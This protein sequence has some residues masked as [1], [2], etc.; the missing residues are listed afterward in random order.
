MNDPRDDIICGACGGDVCPLT[1]AEDGGWRH[2]RITMCR[3]TRPIVR[4]RYDARAARLAAPPVHRTASVPIEINMLVG[5]G[6]AVDETRPGD[7][8]ARFGRRVVIPTRFHFALIMV[9]ATTPAYIVQS[10]VEPPYSGDDVAAAL[11]QF[12]LAAA[13]IDARMLRTILAGD[14]AADGR[15]PD[16]A[17]RLAID[18]QDAARTSWD[19]DALGIIGDG[20]AESLIN[21]SDLQF[22]TNAIDTLLSAAST[23]RIR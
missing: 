10:S 21:G 6:R 5:E 4:A 22:A 2:V 11:H 12:G 3:E 7:S 8:R 9:S 18:A 16:A 15:A 19:H 17:R 23:R 13:T 20:L 1:H 14:K